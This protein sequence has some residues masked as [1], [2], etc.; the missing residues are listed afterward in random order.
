MSDDQIQKLI[1]KTLKNNER[2]AD[3]IS[4]KKETERKRRNGRLIKLGA[5]ALAMF[6][7][8]D[9]NLLARFETA[10]RDGFASRKIDRLDFGLDEPEN[11]FEAL[12]RQ[13]R[14]GAA[15]LTGEASS[16]DAGE[17]PAARAKAGAP[18]AAGGR[19]AAAPAAA[20]APPARTTNGAAV[21]SPPAQSS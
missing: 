3:A 19:V 5:A 12:K 2:L 7:R 14:E 17:S 6:E 21:S 4:K 20:P 8:G 9:L 10:I 15:Q 11:W 1:G 13:I 16:A 18:N